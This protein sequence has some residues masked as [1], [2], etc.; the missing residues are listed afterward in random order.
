MKKWNIGWGVVSTCNMNCEFCYSSKKRKEST[1][2]TYED[3]KRFIDENA[4]HIA[5]IN[6]GTGENAIS[7]DWF[8]LIN[9]I[10]TNYPHIRQA[11]TTNGFVSEAVK[12]NPEHM[13][14]FLEAIDEVDVS[15][16]FADTQRH[17]EFRGQPHA[18]E[19]ALNAMSLCY[20]NKIPLTIVI[21]GSRV[22]LY[23][24][25]LRG[26]FEIAKCFDAIVR[27]NMYRPTNGINDLSSKYILSTENVLRCL[28]FLNENYS[29]LSLNDPLF[30]SLLTDETVVDPSGIDSLRILPNGDITPSTYLITEEYVISNLRSGVSLEHMED[31]ILQQ[32]V[33][34][35]VLP[36]ECNDCMHKDTCCGGVIDRRYLWYGDLSQRDPYC[37]ANDHNLKENYPFKIKLSQDK[38]QS[39]HDGYL[40]TMFF[41][42]R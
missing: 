21:M 34:K 36:K 26:I 5:T 12:R 6:Y 29:V 20:E 39:V 4:M 40:P 24:E 35:K 27:I 3:W 1:D 41:K 31:C 8:R 19:W 33:I 7:E 16:D 32:G 10:R 11:L 30:S 2:I 14:I 22:N 17:G 42:N 15:L 25:N 28:Q 38:F 9:Y 23:E 13:R 18:Y 37:F